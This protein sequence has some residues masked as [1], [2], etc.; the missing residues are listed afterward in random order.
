MVASM[1]RE[2]GSAGLMIGGFYSVTAASLL[3]PPIGVGMAIAGAL[4]LYGKHR[5]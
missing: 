1:A 3:C 2:V 4:W 5:H